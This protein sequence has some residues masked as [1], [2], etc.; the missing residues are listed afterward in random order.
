MLPFVDRLGDI[1][2]DNKN[3][4]E[5]I[6]TSPTHQ[7][8][9]MCLNPGDYLNQERYPDSTQFFRIESGTGIAIINNHVYQLSKGI[10]VVVPPGATHEIINTSHIAPLKLYTIHSPPQYPSDF[11]QQYKFY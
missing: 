6:F 10:A 9:L 3:Y 5:V 1:T 4:R 8:V 7:L 11:V 2:S